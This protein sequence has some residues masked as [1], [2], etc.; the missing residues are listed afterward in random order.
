MDIPSAW[1]TLVNEELR[2]GGSALDLSSG[3]LFRLVLDTVPVPCW[4]HRQG[5]VLYANPAFARLLGAPDANQIAGCRVT[6]LLSPDLRLAF[7]VR[8]SRLLAGQDVPRCEQDL[9]WGRGRSVSVE[10][11]SNLV[12][13]DGEQAI[14]SCFHDITEQR[15]AEAGRRSSDYRYKRIVN[16]RIVGVFEFTAAGLDNANDVFLKMIG[17]TRDDFADGILRWRSISAPEDNELDREKLAELL[18]TGECKS[19]EKEFLRADGVRVPTL[20]GASLLDP[21]P[22]WRAVALVIDISDRRK[23][24]EMRAEKLRLEAISSLAGGMAHNLNNILTGV[25]G[26]ASLLTEGRLAA[27]P[28]R[29]AAIGQQ[30]VQ[31]GERAAVLTGQLLAYS[32]HGR[33][34]VAPVDICALVATESA[35]LDGEL[36]QTVSLLVECEENM[37]RL[38][39]DPDQ[40]QQVLVALVDN[41]VEAIGTREGGIV[42]LVARTE[43]IA[44]GDVLSRIGEPL[45]AGIYCLVEVRDNGEGMDSNT[46]AHAFDP[47]FSTKF[48]GRG[49]SLAAVAGVVRAARGAI[50]VSTSPGLGSVFQVYFPAAPAEGAAESCVEGKK[51]PLAQP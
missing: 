38:L 5:A 4:V 46:L 50:R 49:L 24:Q 35:R 13:F 40:L 1:V 17:R 14:L 19:Y 39:A 42:K 7:E 23:L 16:G 32:G 45:P 41:A 12:T 51:G 6:D 2:L 18:Q 44:H 20:L 21:Q 9:T 30:I 48:P 33:F 34:R 28:S 27:A 36:P 3:H 29:A 25:I 31:A 37:P 22:D 11:S 8:A 10:V 43:T 47:F 26:N 15:R